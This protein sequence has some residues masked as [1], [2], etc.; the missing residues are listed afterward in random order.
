MI[1]IA[2]AAALSADNLRQRRGKGAGFIADGYARVTGRPGVCFIVTGPGMTNIA[3][4]M[5]H[6]YA[7]SVPMLV[8]S[9]INPRDLSGMR[10]VR[11]N[12][13]AH[14]ST[15]S[16]RSLSSATRSWIPRHCR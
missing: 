8:I 7:D 11:L 10:Q 12:E 5:G 4:A 2:R 13:R 15:L 14:S 3:T 6:A 1:V 16:R 9:A